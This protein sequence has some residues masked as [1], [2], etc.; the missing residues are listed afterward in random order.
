M[1]TAA[2][3]PP[4][5]ET[6]LRPP[7]RRPGIVARPDLLARLDE[8]SGRRLTLV[9]APAGWGKTTLVGDWLAGRDAEGAAW[10]ALDVADN[11][12]ARFWRYVAE[13]LRRAG[14]PV[15]DG[16]VGALSGSGETVE[17]GLSALI[18]GLADADCR[19]LL[20][21]DDYH[22]IADETIH[23]AVAFLCANAPD[24]LR[25][26]M[27]SRTDPPIGLARLRARGDLAEF[28]A[29][30]LRFSE[31]DARALLAGAGLSLRDDEVA[32]LRQRTEGW[33]AGL[34][35][36]G[37]S[38][39]GREDAG[40]FIADFA[41]DDR[42]V[43]DYLAD[44]V[45]EGLPAD[46]RDFLLRTSVLGRLS[47]P[48]CDAVAGTSGSARILAELERSNLFL[49]PLD[50]RREWYRYHHLFGELL[51]HELALTSPGD[52]AEL[53]R[54]AAAWHLAEGSV[55]DAVRHAVGAG[56]LDQAADLIAE[57]WSAHLRRGWTVTTQRWLELLPPETVLNDVRL[58][59]AE[60]WLTI[61]LGRPEDAER[62][63]DAAEACEDAWD[64]PQLEASRIAA[65]SLAR[66]LAGDAP[67]ALRFGLQAL[68]ATEG[69]E[70]WW[71]AA[72]CLAAG[73]ALH[74]SDR[75]E[76]SYPVLE[77]CA[78]V[79]RRTGAW[80][81]ALVALCHLAHQD[82]ERGDLDSA[83][84]R[85]REAL[86]Y[87]DEESHAE[88][89]HA[90]GGH[91]GLAHVLAARGQLDEAQAHADRGTELAK[92]GRAPTEIAYCVIVQGEVSLARGDHAMA[93]ACAGDAR[94]LLDGAPAPGPHLREQLAR[95]D[96]GLRNG[97]SARAPQHPA[98]P[99]D[100][101]ERELAVLRMLTGLASA[102]EIADQLYVSHNTVETQIKSIYRKLG[103]A[104]RA[105]AVAR[106]RELGLLAGSLAGGPARG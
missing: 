17:A 77:E 91:S 8:A 3:A 31:G 38:L 2:L 102:R 71:R 60:A 84:R 94:D 47:G 58:C 64:D 80:A 90:A 104:T 45:L 76:E 85:A 92:R 22:L 73:I 55:D 23:A 98:E 24:G 30:D 81:P 67:E 33:A 78:E 53:H 39:R 18:N 42:L 12:P 65:R 74:A 68:A 75:M 69:D 36:A 86:A 61:N 25:V 72:G 35:L 13:A 48:L 100:L 10:V 66:L 9:S 21:L 4:M 56:D 28:R 19:T 34:Y 37:L 95:L 15:E 96:A 103:V 41:G 57:H 27:T 29:P 97:P 46:R 16:V 62:W 32:R 52:V 1:S 101:T 43:V 11:D 87:A 106:G 51:Q 40:R 50:N 70:T 79:G 7:D 44:E 49:V 89:P 88:Y 6:K 14:A 26:V 93:A 5:L 59:L 83:E 82:A 63:L 20:A 105:D 99:T 54:R